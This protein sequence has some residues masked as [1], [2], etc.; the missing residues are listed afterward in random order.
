MS[1]S[2]FWSGTNSVP[3]RVIRQ[4]EAGEHCVCLDSVY[5]TPDQSCVICHGTGKTKLAGSTTIRAAIHF[6]GIDTIYDEDED[7]RYRVH[8]FFHPSSGV[9]KGTLIIYDNRKFEVTECHATST[10]IDC[11]L[12]ER[13]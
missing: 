8:A 6:N 13:L 11:C 12:E 4:Y 5:G 1:V 7:N 9:V 10:H 3:V 2:D